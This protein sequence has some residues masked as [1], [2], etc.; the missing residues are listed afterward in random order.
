M[1]VM[2]SSP[3]N[4]FEIVSPS[5]VV[6]QITSATGQEEQVDFIVSLGCESGC[7]NSSY[8][9]PKAHPF[10]DLTTP[11]KTPHYALSIRKSQVI[12]NAEEDSLSSPRSSSPC[13]PAIFFL[14]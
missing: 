2:S 9:S 14:A 8:S 10:P 7:V 1:T 6:R 12:S 3:T 13:P 4:A 5:S 11:R